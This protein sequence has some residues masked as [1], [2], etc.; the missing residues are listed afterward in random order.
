MKEKL[1]L[2]ERVIMDS[3]SRPGV[4]Q[5]GKLTSIFEIT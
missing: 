3:S 1:R 2:S 5:I 4:Q